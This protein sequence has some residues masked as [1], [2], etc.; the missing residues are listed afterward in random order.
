M[1]I[2]PMHTGATIRR[3]NH[4]T[5]S[6]MYPYF[7]KSLR[8][9]QVYIIIVSKKVAIKLLNILTVKGDMTT[10]FNSIKEFFINIWLKIENFFLRYMSKDIFNVFVFGIILMIILLIILAIMNRD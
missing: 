2:E 6:A 5:N 3:V 10:I 1:G 9:I 7:N 4:F 8:I